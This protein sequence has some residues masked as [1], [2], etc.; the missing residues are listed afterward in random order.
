MRGTR[1]RLIHSS[2]RLLWSAEAGGNRIRLVE[3]LDHVGVEDRRGHQAPIRLRAK[4]VSLSG[5]GP[6]MSVSA[7]V[8]VNGTPSTTEKEQTEGQA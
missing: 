2:P 6:P 1:R 4:I 3:V 7:G 5:F 8:S